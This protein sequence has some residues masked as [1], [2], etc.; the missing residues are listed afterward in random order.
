MPHWTMPAPREDDPN[1]GALKAIQDL[2]AE[3]D[4]LLDSPGG[5]PKADLDALDSAVKAFYQDFEKHV[6]AL[7]HAAPKA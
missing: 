4:K 7:R 1:P 6:K 5:L 2:Q 3:L